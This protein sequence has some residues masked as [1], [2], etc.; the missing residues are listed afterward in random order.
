MR[1]VVQ[2]AAAHTVTIDGLLGETFIIRLVTTI[3]TLKV[4][5]VSPGQL[6][7][8]ILTQDGTGGRS[9]NWGAQALNATTPDPAPH[10]ITTIT[11]IA[12]PGNI[13]QANLAGAWAGES[14][15]SVKDGQR[16]WRPRRLAQSLP[17][18]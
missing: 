5:N 15:Q 11:F 12:Q 14:T 4:V 3:A 6:Y 10:S 17:S 8:F 7:V 2:L 18:R 16:R 1:R 9:V 13:L